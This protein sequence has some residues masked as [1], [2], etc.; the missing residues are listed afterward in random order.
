MLRLLTP[1]KKVLSHYIWKAII[2]GTS[3]LAPTKVVNQ[4]GV[5][6]AQGFVLE[7]LQQNDG[8]STKTQ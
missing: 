7:V 3:Y 8:Y 5:E 4:H 6:E 2:N 1:E